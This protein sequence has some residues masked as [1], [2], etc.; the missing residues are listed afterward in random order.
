LRFKELILKHYFLG[1]RAFN[2]GYPRLNQ[3]FKMLTITL[4]FF[5]RGL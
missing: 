5:I 3:L 1:V 2:L 4:Q